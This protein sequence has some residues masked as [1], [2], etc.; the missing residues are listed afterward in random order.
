VTTGRRLQPGELLIALGLLALGLFVIYETQSIAET[1]GYSQIGPRLFPYVV[2]I[3]LALCGA[4]LG[5]H[6]IFGGWRNLPLDSEGHDAPDWIAFCIISAGIV[7]HMIVIGWAGFIV[8]GTLLYVLVA[9][10]FGSRRLIRDAVIAVV[11]TTVV[12]FV[13]TQALGLKLPGL[14]FVAG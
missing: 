8:A 4:V 3:G 6:A 2:G 11:L 10:G 1:Q 9:R 5:W 12:Y 13:F 14:P 7:L